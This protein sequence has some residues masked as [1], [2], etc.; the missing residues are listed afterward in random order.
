M[1]LTGGGDSV[2]STAAAATKKLG[3]YVLK[4]TAQMFA[5]PVSLLHIASFAVEAQT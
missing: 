5:D 4:H 2:S 1:G 3:S